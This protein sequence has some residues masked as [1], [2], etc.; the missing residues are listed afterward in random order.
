MRVLHPLIESAQVREAFCRLILQVR[1]ARLREV[2]QQTLVTQPASGR[3]RIKAQ[4]DWLASEL[5]PSN[6]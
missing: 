3:A 1:K 2:K 5:P 6:P 4:A